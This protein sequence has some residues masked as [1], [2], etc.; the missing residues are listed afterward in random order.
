MAT[1][2]VWWGKRPP[3]T[4][5]GP[6]PNPQTRFPFLES[7]VSS[8]AAPP[9]PGSCFCPPAPCPRRGVPQAPALGLPETAL[10]IPCPQPALVTDGCRGH[11]VACQD[12][13]GTSFPYMSH[14]QP[15][16]RPAH[17]PW[18]PP[19]ARRWQFLPHAFWGPRPSS[20]HLGS[21]V[22]GG[23]TWPVVHCL[24]CVI[25]DPPPRCRSGA[26]PSKSPATLLPGPGLVSCP[27]QPFGCSLSGN[28]GPRSLVPRP[29]G[30]LDLHFCPD[31]NMARAS[32]HA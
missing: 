27:T 29:S 8:H 12:P 23:P 21:R 30:H 3:C 5:R 1:T 32:V 20:V 10:L 4:C 9:S 6:P 18:S 11:P 17:C 16:P 2:E 28:P 7:S 13:R 19:V 25:A 26:S 31:P 22:P 15:I 24:S 14:F